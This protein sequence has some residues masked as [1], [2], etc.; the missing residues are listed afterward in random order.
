MS[1]ILRRLSQ[2]LYQ[3]HFFSRSI[4]LILI[5]SS[6]IKKQKRYLCLINM[7]SGMKILSNIRCCI[8][9]KTKIR[10]KRSFDTLT[11]NNSLFKLK[12]TIFTYF[13]MIIQIQ[14]FHSNRFSK[15]SITNLLL[16]SPI[17]SFFII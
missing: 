14:I 15:I 3:V 10:F 9:S 12:K 17:L 8:E 16:C 4:P 6:E 11:D 2:K 1:R 5:L 13:K 7:E